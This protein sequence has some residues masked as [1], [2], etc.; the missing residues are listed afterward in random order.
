MFKCINK[1]HARHIAAL[2]CVLA[3]TPLAGCATDDLYAEQPLVPYGGSKM[4]PIKVVN[5]R[6]VVE[7][8]GMWPEDLTET[9]NN[10]MNPNHG[11]AVQSNIAAMAA[12]PADLGGKNRNLPRPLGKI[13]TFAVDKIT[14]DPSGGGGG[15]PAPTP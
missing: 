14:A 15:T 6:A 11:C 9:Q 2:L 5:G 1:Q 4:H 7:K 10:T 12:Y 13:Q 3:A 8:C